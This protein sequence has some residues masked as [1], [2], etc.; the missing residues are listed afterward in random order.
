MFKRISQQNSLVNTEHKE[1]LQQFLP[2]NCRTD[3]YKSSYYPKKYPGLKTD[4]FC[5]RL[6]QE[7]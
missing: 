1:T 4:A 3:I 7:V 6:K 5:S 2:P